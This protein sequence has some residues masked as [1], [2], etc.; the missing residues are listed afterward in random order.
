MAYL[1]VP[2]PGC[3]P[4]V[5]AAF[6]PSPETTPRGRSRRR[7]R[8]VTR[9]ESRAPRPVSSIR[10]TFTVSL[11]AWQRPTVADGDGGPREFDQ[12]AT[13]GARSVEGA[14][15]VVRGDPPHLRQHD[16]DQLRHQRPRGGPPAHSHDPVEAESLGGH[17]PPQS[18]GTHPRPPV[19]PPAPYPHHRPLVWSGN[20]PSS[21]WKAFMWEP[22]PPGTKETLRARC[23]GDL[24]RPGGGPA[25]RCVD[26]CAFRNRMTDRANATT[27]GCCPRSGRPERMGGFSAVVRRLI[28]APHG[29]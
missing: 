12:R 27:Q 28:K 8:R 10:E 22:T 19:G 26:P 17:P 9:S 20:R 4:A 23:P 3:P 13:W 24:R 1:P 7:R 6:R 18:G 16:V 15:R 25:R 11:P 21:E 5:S 14:H 29:G 2:A